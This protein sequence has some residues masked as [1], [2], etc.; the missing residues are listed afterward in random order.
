MRQSSHHF[1]SSSLFYIVLVQMFQLEAN[2]G[3]KE[4]KEE[5]KDGVMA[6]SLSQTNTWMPICTISD[7]GFDLL[8]CE[9]ETYHVNPNPISKA[10]AGLH[11]Q[12]SELVRIYPLDTRVHSL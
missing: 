9:G 5:K 6:Y 7:F 4:E 1:S 8:M 2:A 3:A 10:S 12:T 11:E